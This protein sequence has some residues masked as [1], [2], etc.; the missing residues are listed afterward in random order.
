MAVGVPRFQA[1]RT[2]TR[3]GWIL[4]GTRF[5][6]MFGYGLISVVLVLYLADN[7]ELYA[8]RPSD[9]FLWRSPLCQ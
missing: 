5:V 4:F 9:A 7:Y 2:L 1:L 6:Q 3:D 8:S